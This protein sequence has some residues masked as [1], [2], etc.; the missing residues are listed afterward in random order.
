MQT[1]MPTCFCTSEHFS[2][3]S[4]KERHFKTCCFEIV[5]WA[6][7]SRSVIYFSKCFIFTP[8]CFGTKFTV[9]LARAD[10]ILNFKGQTLARICTASALIFWLR[11][12]GHPALCAFGS[13]AHLLR[14]WHH[15]HDHLLSPPHFGLPRNPHDH[16]LPCVPAQTPG[17]HL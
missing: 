7:N 4:P 9:S 12:S 10:S 8:C 14:H 11:G 13:V 17:W 2:M 1:T 5:A 16:L 15:H 3:T 6:A